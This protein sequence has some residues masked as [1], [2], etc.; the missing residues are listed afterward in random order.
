MKQ[1]PTTSDMLPGS[2]DLFQEIDLDVRFYEKIHEFEGKRNIEG[3]CLT[4]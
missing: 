4:S 2:H 3:T 1:V